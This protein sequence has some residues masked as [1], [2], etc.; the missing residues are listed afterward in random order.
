MFSTRKLLELTAASEPPRRL[1]PSN[2]NEQH[3]VVSRLARSP[4]HLWRGQPGV[5]GGD[6]FVNRQF[7]QRAHRPVDSSPGS[8]AALQPVFRFVMRERERGKKECAFA[9]RGLVRRD[10]WWFC[11]LGVLTRRVNV[12]INLRDLRAAPLSSREMK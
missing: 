3:R 10:R 1:G 7:A 9:L 11:W 8:T 4:A 12:Q 2:N 6:R 5:G